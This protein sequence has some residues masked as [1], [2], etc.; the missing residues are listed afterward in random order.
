MR[1]SEEGSGGAGL[2]TPSPFSPIR[3][4]AGTA[5]WRRGLLWLR[6][7]TQ[8]PPCNRGFFPEKVVQEAGCHTIKGV[9]TPGVV[10]TATLSGRT[11]LLIAVAPPPLRSSGLN[12]LW[13]TGYGIPN[14]QGNKSAGACW[15]G[16][17]EVRGFPPWIGRP[18]SRGRYSFTGSRATVRAPSPPGSPVKGNSRGLQLR[19]GPS[20][21]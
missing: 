17:G 4:R 11:S 10:K 6:R 13:L 3:G 7:N 16:G 1:G 12:R 21:A 14:L 9:D 20:V 15:Q 5:A 19:A 2:E 18:G 8:H